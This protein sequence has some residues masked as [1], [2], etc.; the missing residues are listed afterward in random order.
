MPLRLNGYLWRILAC[1]DDRASRRKPW[2]RVRS[3]LVRGEVPMLAQVSP[4][5]L[6]LVLASRAAAQPPQAPPRDSSAR[7]AIAGTATIRGTVL[8]GDTGR[9]LRR[10]RITAFAPELAG[11]P[12][13]ASTDA[14][15]RYELRELPPGRY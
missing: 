2:V 11:Q 5:L 15:G 14:D 9:P 6:A 8:A 3:I 7:T 1:C 4:I 10:A 12:R 13:N